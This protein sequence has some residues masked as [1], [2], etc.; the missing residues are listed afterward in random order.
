VLYAQMGQYERADQDF[1]DAALLD[2][3][4]ETSSNAQALAEIQANRLGD[5]LNTV[6][7]R[8]Q[9]HPAD[10]FLHYLLSEILV[11]DGAQPQSPEFS[12]AIAAAER[13]VQLKPDFVLARDVLSRLY[14]ESG[15]TVKAITQCRLT[16]KD[17]PDDQVALYRLIRALRAEN[18]T[19]Y[20]A[21][22]S[23]L[24]HRLAQVREQAKQREVQTSQ[25]KLVEASV[26]TL[27]NKP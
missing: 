13:A 19:R 3:N 15:Q 9:Q 1:S 21:E 5:A 24:L 26:D 2:P 4:E 8:L 16:L 17:D 11:K 23:Q 18:A 12:R 14:L 10:P 25:Y 20:D 6:E 27:S 22:I 7:K